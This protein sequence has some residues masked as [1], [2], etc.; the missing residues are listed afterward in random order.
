MLGARLTSYHNLYFLIKMMENAR[1]AIK[2]ERFYEFKEEFK[3]NYQMGKES[4]W[5]KPKS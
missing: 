3:K 5:I 2:E 4:E 1:E